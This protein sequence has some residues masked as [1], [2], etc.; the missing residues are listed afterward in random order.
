MK[1]KSAFLSICAGSFLTV[2]IPAAAMADTS[3]VMQDSSPNN[4]GEILLFGLA[5]LILLGLTFWLFKSSN[6]LDENFNE[7][8]LDGK[9][10]LNGHLNDLET[11]Q[12]DVLIHRGDALG[13]NEENAQIKNKNKI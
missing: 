2:F 8:E 10:W 13:K 4:I 5:F 7:N 11:N 6:V 3:P 9:R 12:L 1:T